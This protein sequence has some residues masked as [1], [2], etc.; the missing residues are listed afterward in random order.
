MEFCLVPLV[1]L[2]IMGLSYGGPPADVALPHKFLDGRDQVSHLK[3]LKAAPKGRPCI[4]GANCV[5]PSLAWNI[6]RISESF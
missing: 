3:L 4:L 6:A 1:V 5:Y 2:L